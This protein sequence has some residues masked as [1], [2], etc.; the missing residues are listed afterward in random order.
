MPWQRHV[1]QPPTEEEYAIFE[2]KL[3]NNCHIDWLSGCCVDHGSE[4]RSNGCKRML[5]TRRR[6]R[7]SRGMHFTIRRTQ[8]SDP[9]Q[10]KRRKRST[11]V[12]SAVANI[13]G[14]IHE[15]AIFTRELTTKALMFGG[16][17]LMS[18]RLTCSALRAST[19]RQTNVT[20]SFSIYDGAMRRVN[21][22]EHGRCHG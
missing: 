3:K 17:S 19:R 18:A 9:E 11:S 10:R 22:T 14:P 7:T 5:S 8:T 15:A 6:V 4:A 21:A 16:V 20:S 1:E 13:A 12:A 2:E